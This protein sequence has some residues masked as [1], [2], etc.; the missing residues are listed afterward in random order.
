MN[1]AH[2][3]FVPRHS[4]PSGSHQIILN[5]WLKEENS[6]IS[7]DRRNGRDVVRMPKSTYLSKYGGLSDPNIEEDILLKKTNLLKHYVK[8]PRM[9]HTK[10]VDRLYCD[11]LE[12]KPEIV[13]YRS[14]FFKC[15]L[16]FI[17]KLTE[18]ERQSC[19][20]IVC[21]NAHTKLEGINTFRRIEKLQTIASAS[22]YIISQKS[23]D[24][25]S[26][27]YPDRFSKKE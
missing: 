1:N 13:C 11:F 16:F 8:A 7:N 27:L 23:K 15:K 19:L 20:F 22:E 5:F 2:R 9:L 3:E 21:Q 17:E 18:R 14:A 26:S 12:E 4:M 25:D 6:I 10:S 24:I